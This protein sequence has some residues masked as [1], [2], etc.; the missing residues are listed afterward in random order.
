MKKAFRIFVLCLVAIALT[1]CSTVKSEGQLYIN[2]KLISFDLAGGRLA[3]SEL[4][5]AIAES[6]DDQ[7][8]LPVPERDGYTFT[9]WLEAGSESPIFSVVCKEVKEPKLYVAQWEI[10]EYKVSIISRLVSG[11]SGDANDLPVFLDTSYNAETEINL[12][13]LPAI[14][15]YD[16][17][18][19][20]EA[21]AAESSALQE[22]KMD[23]G[24]VFGDKALVAL[25]KP[26][27]CKVTVDV[28]GNI[29]EYEYTYKSNQVIEIQNPEQVGYDFLGWIYEDGAISEVKENSIVVNTSYAGNISIKANMQVIEYPITYLE[30]GLIVDDLVVPVEDV[31]EE[32]EDTQQ[33]EPEVVTNPD[34]YTVV[35]DV[36]FINPTREGFTFLGWVEKPEGDIDVNKLTPD[37]VLEVTDPNYSIVAGTTGDKVLVA[38]WGRNILKVNYDLNGGN[39]E[40]ENPSTYIYGQEGFALN[41][42]TREFYN[43]IG[44]KDLKS[45]AVYTT[46]FDNTTLDRNISLVAQWE[47]IEYA[48]NYNL[49]GG[50][51]EGN[52]L[53]SY[54]YETK[55]FTLP[56]PVKEGYTFIG[57][58]VTEEVA[59]DPV[60]F[61]LTFGVDGV[62]LTIK[63]FATKTEWVFP[64]GISENMLKGIEN[65]LASQFPEAELTSNGNII[66]L[67]VTDGDPTILEGLIK[68]LASDAGIIFDYQKTQVA[69]VGYDSITIYQGSH[70]EKAYK[71]NWQ[72]N[73]YTI[74]YAADEEYGP[75][76]EPEVEVYEYPTKYTA[77]EIVEIKNLEKPGYDFMG[78][79]LED[80]EYTEA[81]TDLVLEKGSIG[82]RVYVPLFKLHDYKVDL[83]LGGGSVDAPSTFT[84]EDKNFT[85]GE[86]TRANYIFKGW[87]CADGSLKNKVTVECANAQ[88]VVLKA[89]WEPI[90]YTI[91]Y[92]LSGG[93]LPVGTVDNVTTYNA[94]MES[95]TLVNPTKESYEFAGWIIKGREN[96]ELPTINYTFDTS[97]GGNVTLVATWKEKEYKISYSLNGGAFEYADSN[98]STFTNFVEDFVLEA[99]HRA[100]YTFLGWV[101][102]GKEKNR[103]VVDYVIKASELRSN[104]YLKAMWKATTYAITYNLNGGYF[105]RGTA[106]NATSYTIEDRGFILANPVRDG[107]EFAGWVRTDYSTTD[108]ASLVLRV[109]TSKG[110]DLSYDALWKAKS[111]TISYN[112]DGGTY[113]YG[114]SNPST[115]TADSCFTLANPHKDGY[116]FLGW[117]QSGDPLERVNQ[118]VTVGPNV[119]G[120]LT[121]YAIYEQTLVAVGEA[122][123]QQ[124]QIIELGKSDIPRPD[125]V[126]KAPEDANYH[127]EKAY[128]S[129]SDFITNLEKASAKCREYLA[130]YL[131]TQVS[132]VVKNVNGITYNNVSTE[133]STSVTRSEM[134]EYWEDVNGG[135]WV[136]MRIEK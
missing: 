22:V 44:W 4:N 113:Q 67:D 92:D 23:K 104:V 26:S 117:V 68:N 103:P 49:D 96:K 58:S 128:A 42:P 27:T 109:D 95:F 40:S 74:D 86:A 131:E 28:D 9:G 105:A 17:A 53:A 88:D 81:K 114:N 124:T 24:S 56:I 35:E 2:G 75:R 13:A 63:V 79:V 82:N 130:A 6:K 32:V 62:E 16:F 132:S 110:G 111:Y 90:N 61:T 73:I 47:P 122:T 10:I 11:A 36:S 134:V 18:G 76:I 64:L 108:I 123:L 38:V 133:V 39:L 45:G 43:F 66:T 55:T 46:S 29:S 80:Q 116:T 87:L 33:E 50:R 120:N 106:V 77:E 3:Q 7:V 59:L 37:M 60:L 125:W 48:I 12:Q 99:P 112:L 21:G 107:Y 84:I 30:E 78:W 97:N 57:W 14:T 83:D 93:K 25:W 136:L 51:F 72:V 91:S 118:T 41:A 121:F 85:I 135:V 102:V 119:T 70:G 94:D 115:Y 20:I 129:G 126:I 31:S 52:Y 34:S 89:V 100:G 101:E 19:W 54:T 65:Y 98:P 69:E 127:Y 8:T 15:G 1:A 71:A 5:R